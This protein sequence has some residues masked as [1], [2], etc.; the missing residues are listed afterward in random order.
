MINSAAFAHSLQ[1]WIG[2]GPL[3]MW[4]LVSASPS[5]IFWRFRSAASR[6]TS[7][8]K[9][10]ADIQDRIGPNRVGPIGI[11]Q[12]LADAVKMLAKED[13]IP[14]GGGHASSSTSRR[15]SSS[16]GAVGAFAV[17]PLGKYLVGADINI[18]VFYILAV[19]TIIAPGI[20]LGSWALAEQMV[21]PRR[22]P[23]RG[24]DRQLRDSGRRSRSSPS[25]RSRGTLQVGS[26][27]RAAG[28]GVVGRRNGRITISGT[29]S[30]T[31]SRSSRSFSSSSADSPRRTASPSICPKRSRSW[32]R[33]S[34]PSFPACAS[35][36]TRWASSATSSSCRRS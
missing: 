4:A 7:S 33:A 24:A 31:R 5:S 10:A 30:T 8:A 19:T 17:L 28:L 1:T 13:F 12:F 14:D 35:A 22:T 6:P 11:L 20:L 36:S 16:S 15:C 3:W 2:F 29:S 9:I 26:D 34:T 21:A 27:R 25:S 23:R 18:G 32:C